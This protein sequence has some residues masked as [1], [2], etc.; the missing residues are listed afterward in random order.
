[1]EGKRTT[2][3]AADPTFTNSLSAGGDFGHLSDEVILMILNL[4]S[5]KDLYNLM[6]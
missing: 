1:M 3:G 2:G 4:L 5:P 6:K